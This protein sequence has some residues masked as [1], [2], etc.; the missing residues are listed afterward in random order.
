MKKSLLL[1]LCL[2]VIGCSKSSNSPS[3][4][5]PVD[6]TKACGV[7]RWQIKNVFDAGAASIDWT[8]PASSIAAQDSFAQIPVDVF[9]PRLDFE[10]QTVSI[11]CTI[12]AFKQE[13]DSD[14]HI[15]MQDP[16]MDSMIGEIPSTSCAEVA[17]SHHAADFGAASRW[18]T[19]HLGK[20]SGS[21]QHVNIHVTVTGV[22]FQDFAHGQKGHARNYREIHPVTKIE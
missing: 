17:A 19:D 9:T 1:G 10:K 4:S 13:D 18:V 5:A 20:P 11:P 21:F 7:E 6:S 3:E 15:I 12:V 16:L 2:F 8:A 14:I 22:L